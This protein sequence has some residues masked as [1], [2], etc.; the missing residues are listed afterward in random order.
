MHCCHGT[1]VKGSEHTGLI[2]CQFL[3][4]LGPTGT[5]FSVRQGAVAQ[6]GPNFLRDG[7][8][9]EIAPPENSRGRC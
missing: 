5:K 1:K 6:L 4:T 9:G 8:G 7:G 3:S 2:P